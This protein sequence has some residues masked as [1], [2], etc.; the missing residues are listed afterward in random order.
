[1]L[2]YTVSGGSEMTPIDDRRRVTT[3]LGDLLHAIDDVAETQEEAF[4]VLE[5]MLDEESISFLGFA[6]A[7]AA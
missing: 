3:S 7:A 6:F 5:L 1:M 2:L 4:A